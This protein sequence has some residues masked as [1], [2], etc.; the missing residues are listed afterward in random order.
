MNHDDAQGENRPN[1][2]A[3]NRPAILRAA[4]DGEQ[5]AIEHLAAVPDQPADDHARLAFEKT[6]R[7]RTARVMHD[8]HPTAPNELRTAIRATL[9]TAQ[10]DHNQ[11]DHPGVLQRIGPAGLGVLATAAVIVL[12]AAV[13]FQ[14]LATTPGQAPDSAVVRQISGF[15]H[16]EH[17]ASTGTG[18]LS[19]RFTTPEAPDHATQFVESAIGQAPTSLPDHIDALNQRGFRLVGLARCNKPL[20]SINAKSAH[21]LFQPAELH[22]DAD[23]ASVPVS[24]FIA[25]AEPD[26]GLSPNACYACIKSQQA[27]EPVVFW[28][29]DGFVYVVHAASP[30]AVAAARQSLRAPTLLQAI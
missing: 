1:P 9:A 7:E 11:S 21:L 17:D 20:P 5:W 25:R 4:A 29:A 22:Q 19:P 16:A 26:D 24:V 10:I 6:L 3:L 27:G 18:P 13:L 23:P 14:A 2:D 28:K 8:A 15:V 30:E 12:S